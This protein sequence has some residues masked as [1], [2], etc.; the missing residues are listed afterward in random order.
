MQILARFLRVFAVGVIALFVFG[1]EPDVNMAAFE[2]DNADGISASSNSSSS[3]GSGLSGTWR[4]ISATGQVASTLRLSESGGSVSGTLTWPR[5]DKRS[6]SGSRSGSSVRLNIGGG[7][8][9]NMT[10]SGDSLT[11]V[12]SKKGGGSYNLRFQR[13]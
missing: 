5:G 4:G 2:K 11:G 6:V 7:D 3:R 9:W 8:A 10:L 1:C 13:Q 12:G